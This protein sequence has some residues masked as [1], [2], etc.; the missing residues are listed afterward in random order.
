MLGLVLV[1][2]A[3]SQE[4][5]ASLGYA[6]VK[7]KIDGTPAGRFVDVAVVPA[8]RTLLVMTTGSGSCPSV[9]VR[10]DVRSPSAVDVELDGRYPGACTGDASATTTLVRLPADVDVSRVLTVTLREGDVTTVLEARTVTELPTGT[11]PV[12]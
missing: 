10:L 3:C 4:A 1:L 9:P 7:A 8:E 2:A 12:R 11:R 6:T 5:P